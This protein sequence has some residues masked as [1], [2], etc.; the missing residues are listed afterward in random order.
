MHLKG[1]AGAPVLV[2]GIE[3]VCCRLSGMH[4]AL[5]LAVNI[6]II[7]L[8]LGGSFNRPAK[9]EFAFILGSYLKGTN[10]WWSFQPRQSYSGEALIPGG[11]NQLSVNSSGFR[12][13]WQCG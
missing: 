13:L 9:L 3:N 6:L 8:N 12:S 2:T 10:D 1:L 5:S 11:V 4:Q 7:Q